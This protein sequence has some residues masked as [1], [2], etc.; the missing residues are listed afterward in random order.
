MLTLRDL[1]RALVA[2]YVTAVNFEAIIPHRIVSVQVYE[3]CKCSDSTEYSFIAR[4]CFD[5]PEAVDI[6]AVICATKCP[7]E[8]RTS[9][10]LENL[11]MGVT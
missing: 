5:L 3:R 11:L 6:T 1:S 7:I 9:D 2:G 4:H 10:C 8:A